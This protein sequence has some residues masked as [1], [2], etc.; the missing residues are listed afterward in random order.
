[1]RPRRVL[2][3]VLLIAA[4][5]GA[6]RAGAEASTRPQ[7]AIVHIVKRGETLSSIAVRYGSSVRAIVQANGLSGTTIYP[8]QSLLVPQ[9]SS[10]SGSASAVPKS[11]APVSRSSVHVVQAGD[12]L[13]SIA[14]R[15]GSTVAALKQANGLTS[16]TIYVG[17]SLAIPS[18]A[19]SSFAQRQYIPTLGGTASAAGCGS[20]YTVQPGDTLS[21]IA[22]RCGL[23]VSELRAYNGMDGNTVLRPGHVL[24]LVAPAPQ[25]ESSTVSAAEAAP[26]APQP[27]ITRVPVRP[28]PTYSGSTP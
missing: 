26:A 2:T 4:L 18:G 7:S 14:A 22:S 24:V 16:D 19:A 27:V 28:L 17:Q 21:G 1:M 9:G 13:S 15:Y 6:T 25:E 3:I 8:G 11:S 5:L 23:T 10:G 12:T 20:T